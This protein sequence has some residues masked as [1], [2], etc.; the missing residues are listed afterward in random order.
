MGYFDVPA[1]IELVK[2]QTDRRKISYIGH[3][4]G[5][6]QMF[7]ALTTDRKKYLEDSLNLFIALA[8]VTRL[9]HTRSKLLSFL[10]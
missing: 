2:K 10:V 6:T 8:P 4:M 9:D 3:S 7:Y 5:T 1:M